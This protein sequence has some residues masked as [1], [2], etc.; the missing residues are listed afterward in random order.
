MPKQPVE[1]YR[2]PQIVEETQSNNISSY[3]INAP[4]MTQPLLGAAHQQFVYP[5]Q[6]QATPPVLPVPQMVVAPPS[7]YPSIQQPILVKP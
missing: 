5:G 1:S 7:P 2:P 4:H 6:F 3:Q